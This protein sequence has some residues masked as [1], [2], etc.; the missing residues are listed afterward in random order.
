MAFNKNKALESALKYLNQGKVAQAI[1]EYQQILR[2]DPKDQAT[3]MT[4]GDLYA[5]Q[6]DMPHAIEYF[7]RLAQV[8]LGDGFNSKAI[9]IYK[10]IAKLAPAELAPLERLAD[11]YVQQGVLSE[12][13]PLFLQIAEVH[14]KANRSQKAVEVLQRLLDV[15]PD[16]PRVQM[17]LAEL[18]NVMGQKKEAAHTY[19]SY[20]QRVLDRGET[21]EA[22]KLVDRALELDASNASALL[23]KG[24]TLASAKKPEEAIKVLSAHPEADAGAELTDLI[25]NLEMEAGHTA[26]CIERGRKQLARGHAHS[27]QLLRVTDSLIAAGQTE[28]ALPLLREL[29]GPMIEAGEQDKFLKSLT[30]LTQHSP[31]SIEALDMLVDF[32]RHTSDPFRANTALSQLADAYAAKGDCARAVQL[33]EELADRNKEDERVLEKLNQMRARAGGAPAPA[34]P[35][36]PPVAAQEQPVEELGLESAIAGEKRTFGPTEEPQSEAAAVPAPVAEHELSEDAQ[37]YVA[38]ALTDADL[39]SSYGLT[40]KATALLENV[41]QRAPRH[42]PSLE[43]LLDLYLGA[44]NERRTAEIAA[45]L[46]QIYRQ[47]GDSPNADHFA[48]MRKRFQKAAGLEEQELPAPPPP[49]APPPV[50][51]TPEVH[52]SIPHVAE[53]AP[54]AEPVGPAEFEIPLMPVEAEPEHPVASAPVVP[55]MESPA[56]E[57]PEPEAPSIEA[58]VP[59]AAAEAPAPPQAAEAVEELDL[60]DEWEAMS[61]EIQAPPEV[62][63]EPV[64]AVVPVDEEEPV[65]TNSPEESEQL[66]EVKPAAFDEVAPGETIELIDE[67]TEPEPASAEAE[68]PSAEPVSAEPVAAEPVSAASSN[69]DAPHAAAGVD[70]ETAPEQPAERPA[71]PQQP[72]FTTDDF[73]KELV[74]EIQDSEPSE[75]IE[76]PLQAAPVEPS[77]AQIFEPSRTQ[78]AEPAAVAPPKPE[79]LPEPIKAAQAPPAA[80]H[81]PHPQ[82]PVQKKF[83][84]PVHEPVPQVN[85]EVL[86]ELADVF[87]E[88]RD[89]LGE[90]EAEEEDLETHYNLGIAYREMGLLDEAIGEFQ[91]VAKA[92]QKGKPFAYAMNCATLMAVSFL[93]KGEPKIAAFWYQRALETPGVDQETEL[94]LR[95]D[96]GVALETAGESKSALDSFQQVYARNID[97]RDVADRIAALQRHAPV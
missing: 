85:A 18:Y 49:V 78:M 70:E 82:P 24:K 29:R 16:N 20:A 8:Y 35:Q 80:A 37:R 73:I 3:L 60:S 79:P 38:Q 31:Q 55:L 87:Q 10:K 4:V 72:T 93:D 59:E 90:A 91:R 47:R 7:E 65:A 12:A 28:E 71:A 44:G 25:F 14:L 53:T 13:R 2:H 89:G 42:T 27:A 46:E 74:S 69:G 61:R 5:R 67:S 81:V 34:A 96:L 62:P 86:N 56:T 33:M 19:L 57:T 48:E 92:I 36:P 9:A 50:A 6:S 17:R 94:A 64:P 32:C 66:E 41:L 63:A 51:A 43:R 15:E 84:E 23:L 68:P 58:P 75:T 88:F 40:Q 54:P 97:Y 95:Y 76:V 26:N 52:A 1:S 83:H 77:L 30:S 39:F 22:L 11:L 21:D 45:Q